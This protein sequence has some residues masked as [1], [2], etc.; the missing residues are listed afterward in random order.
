MIATRGWF[1][2]TVI[3]FIVRPMHRAWI[4]SAL[5]AGLAGTAMAQTAPPPAPTP[6]PAPA[7]PPPAPPEPK[8]FA[9]AIDDPMLAPI[10]PATRTLAGW[11]EAHALLATHATALLRAG[12]AVARADA[13]VR[14]ARA[15]LYPTARATAEAELDVLHPGTAPGV[16]TTADTTPTSPLVS[17]ALTATQPLIDVPARHARA[18][19][20]AE[21]TAATLDR[22]DAERQVAQRAARAV[23]AVALAERIAE[24]NRVGLRQALE[25]AALS[26]RTRELGAATELDTVRVEQDV[27]VARAALIAGDEQVRTA[28]EALGLALGVG[29]DVGVAPAAATALGAAI[30]RTCRPLAGEA[31]ADVAAARAGIAAARARTSQVRA[32]YL[33]SLDLSTSLFAYTADP[34]PGKLGAWTVAAVLSVPLWEGGLRAGLIAEREAAVADAVAVA[35][36][37]ERAAATEIAQAGRGEAVGEALVG[38]AAE[39][40]RLAARV[41]AMTRRSFEIGR[42]TSLELVQSAAALRQAEVALALR[43]FE[44]LRAQVDRLLSEARCVP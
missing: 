11:D 16:P 21:R 14:Q 20:R 42:A 1:A 38:A 33:P 2:T 24:L 39:A 12:A 3:A 9:A 30:A 35:A 15:T 10:A 6:Q 32:G 25:R 5:V 23:V 26:R 40:A 43:E 44:R 28:R 8:P 4:A 29:G 19:A 41:D 37:V 27:A 36:D 13:G 7:P 22:A 31:R 34:A 18:A 17:I